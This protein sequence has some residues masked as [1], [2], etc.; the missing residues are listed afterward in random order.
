MGY[1][2]LGMDQAVPLRWGS[3]DIQAG[4]E[5]GRDGKGRAASVV[6]CTR[7][8]VSYLTSLPALLTLLP[9]TLSKNKNRRK[10]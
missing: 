6:T 5:T 10:K 4:H 1:V 8:S 2:V 9:L 7:K 3:S